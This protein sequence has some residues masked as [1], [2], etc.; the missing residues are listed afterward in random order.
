MFFV[1]ISTQFVFGQ[2]LCDKNNWPANAIEGGFK[3]D[4][5]ITVGC[6]PLTIKLKDLSGGTDIRY[7]F[8]YNGKT[9]NALDKVGNKD[10]VN[11]LFANTNTEVYRILQYGK[12]NGK[13]MYACK[14]ISVRPNTKP[15]FSYSPCGSNVEIA[16]SKAKE[17]IYQYYEITCNNNL[18]TKVRIDSAQLPFAISKNVTYP[19]NLKVEGFPSGPSGCNSVHSQTAL[20]LNAANYPN[21]FALPFDPNIDEVTMPNKSTAIL[22]FRGSENPNGYNLNI[23]DNLP[24]SPYT[25]F[26]TG[27]KPGEIKISLPDSNKS[28][29]FFL[30][31]STCG[32]YTSEI[33]TIPI[34]DLKVIENNIELNWPTY[35][36]RI[37]NRAYLAGIN[38]LEKEI[39]IE[40]KIANAITN[41]TISPNET[42][43]RESI[44]ECLNNVK[45]RV[46]LL[47]KGLL[48]G[49][50]Y[51][52]V[53]YSNWSE[54][55]SDSV[56]PSPLTNLVAT[57][58]NENAITINFTDNSNWKIEKEKYFLSD[59]LN[60]LLDSLT[61]NNT[62]FNIKLAEETLKQCYKISFR[63]KCGSIS[64]FSPTVCPLHL[65]VLENDDLGWTTKSPFGIGEI[66]EFRLIKIDEISGNQI[67]EDTYLKDQNKTTPEMEGIEEEAKFKILAISTTNTQSLSNLATIP[68][69][70]E[71]HIPS[72]FTPNSDA[73][74]DLLE[75][76]GGINKVEQY[77]LTIY[78]RWGSV[79]EHI[80]DKNKKWDGLFAGQ[81]TVPGVYHYFLKVTLK[82]GEVLNKIGKF[83]ILK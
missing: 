33:C 74:N 58:E 41:I 28:Y 7:D 52:S 12:K 4:G 23:R 83:E 16:I 63:D 69:D 64:Q 78:D 14:T 80:K 67:E 60:Q 8:Y 34:T 11:A 26:R 59:S 27:I 75:V 2:G 49:F 10:S 5:D 20:A 40:K 29:C 81:R 9:A 3:I 56:L 18:S 38:T 54:I 61:V 72:I 6:S 43:Y 57:V 45:I 48:A 30:N 15:F 50:K 68:I 36:D 73:I 17:N 62:L 24:N 55:K 71:F 53:I 37:N 79:I 47:A 66:K 22:K 32:E 46:K 19:A 65:E 1:L 77:S 21:G 70:I 82:N 25:L 31:R 39:I 44:E 13:D 76:K 42:Q 51:S 35:P